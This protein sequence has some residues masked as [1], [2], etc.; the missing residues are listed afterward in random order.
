MFSFFKKKA[1]INSLQ[2][3]VSLEQDIHSHI[4]PGLDDGS[5][6][7]ETSIK[8]VKGLYDLGIRNTIATPHIIGDTYRNDPETIKPILKQLQEEVRNEGLDIKIS[9]GAEYMLDDYFLTLL[10]EKKE[11]MPIHKNIL[12]TEFS[13]AVAP[14]N[15][16]EM[17]FAI[18]T[19]GYQPILAHPERYF[20]LHKNMKEYQHLKDLGFLFQVNL[21]SFTGYYGIPVLKAARYLI[22]KGLVDHVGTDM[23]H[24]RHLETLNNNLELIRDGIGDRKYN[25]F[26]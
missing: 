18:L 25:M 15:I 13:Y 7:M 16:D 22:D 10:R 23:H 1:Q 21:L 24:T 8:L 14:L 20:Y 12:L 2:K 3:F 19:A 11:L 17:V 5:P 6:D 9:A 4:L 26:F